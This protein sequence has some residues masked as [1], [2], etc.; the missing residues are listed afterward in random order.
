MAKRGNSGIPPL[1]P[2]MLAQARELTSQQ[3]RTIRQETIKFQG[4][5]GD[6]I[7]VIDNGAVIHFRFQITDPGEHKIYLFDFDQE[8]K[9]T[10]IK[11]LIESPAVG[12]EVVNAEAT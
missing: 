9:E 8:T 3:P 6:F 10:Y 11:M 5:T 2:D 1:T 7:A 4:C 12:E